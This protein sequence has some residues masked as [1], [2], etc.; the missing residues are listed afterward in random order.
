MKAAHSLTGDDVRLSKRVYMP[1]SKLRGFENGKIGPKDGSD[2]VG[3]NY[4]WSTN[5]ELS[6]PNLLPE[7]TKIDV[8]G[9]ID[10]GNL[11]NVDY[12]K[13]IDDSNEIRSSA[14][15]NTSWVSPVGPM[16]F[17][18]SQNI[19]KAKTD[20]AA[21]DRAKIDPRSCQDGS[22]IVLGRFFL[23]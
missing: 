20:V 7:S 4:A 15:I 5:L 19:T 12:D 1:A 22:R 16:T 17:I 6:L 10:A 18:F 3:G 8:S 11:W 2:Y 14:G 21:Q 23:S 13:G 9:F